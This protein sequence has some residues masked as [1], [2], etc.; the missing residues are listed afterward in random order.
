MPR[1]GRT[2]CH[3]PHEELVWYAWGASIVKNTNLKHPMPI[4]LHPSSDHASTQGIASR[5]D[6]RPA[7][8]IHSHPT[9]CSNPVPFVR[10]Q[11]P[12]LSHGLLGILRGTPLSQNLNDRRKYLQFPNQE[13][14][15]A[16]CMHRKI[17]TGTYIQY[18]SWLCIRYSRIPTGWRVSLQSV[19]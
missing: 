11:G 4:S 1:W 9:V 19:K 15:Q 6:L 8:A 16:M 3:K 7:R 2:L 13:N 12:W 10:H 14:Y 18:T 5:L 17:R